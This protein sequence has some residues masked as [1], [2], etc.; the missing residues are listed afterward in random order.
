MMR[1]TTIRSLVGTAA[2]VPLIALSVGSPTPEAQATTAQAGDEVVTTLNGVDATSFSDVWAVGATDAH[3]CASQHWDGVSW[4]QLPTPNPGGTE[5][6]LLSVR[7]LSSTD[8]WAAGWH[9]TPDLTT[10]SLVLHWDGA[11]WTQVPSVNPGASF[12]S[13]TSLTAIS[14]DDIWAYGLTSATQGAPLTPLIEH[15]NGTDWSLAS[16]GLAHTRAIA[17]VAADDLWAVGSTPLHALVR[18]YDGTSWST[19][20]TPNPG[21]YGSN[22]TSVVAIRAD[23]VWAVGSQDNAAGHPTAR[24]TFLHW[25][26]LAWRQ[27][28]ASRSGRRG[29]LGPIYDSAAGGPDDAWVL[30]RG[31]GDTA[32]VHWNGDAWQ[33]IGYPGAG[34]TLF[35]IDADSRTDAWAVGQNSQG[36]PAI[37]SYDGQFWTQY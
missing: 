33:R 4:T 31:R 24:H 30:A 20:T 9:T 2:V 1:M 5:S 28:K 16:G 8:V 34:A 25:D 29:H 23:D 3:H 26:G 11:S 13:L 15:W 14:T 32:F 19:A 22:L 35:D 27:V 6:S 10:L 21:R 17:G 36:L 12:N 37:L 18:H 7:R